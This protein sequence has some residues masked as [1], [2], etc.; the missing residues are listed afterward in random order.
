MKTF[1]YPLCSIIL[2]TVVITFSS[3]S[4]DEEKKVAEVSFDGTSQ[5]VNEA[6]GFIFIPFD[7]DDGPIADDAELSFEVSGTATLDEDYIYDGWDE[8][9]VYF[10][11]VDDD[12]FEL[13]ETLILEITDSEKV[14]ISSPDTHTVTIVDNDTDTDL[15]IDLTWNAGGG[16]PGDVDMDLILWE[17]D[18]V[19][20]IFSDI[21]A[22]AQFGTAFES[23][24][25]PGSAADGT[26]G[27]T[28]QYWEG[29]SNNLQFTVTFTTEN[30]TLEG[31]E[32]ELVFSETYTLNN[33]NS[34]SNVLIEQLFD[35]VGADYN[36]FSIIDVP[37]SGSR[38]K[39][40]EIPLK[41]TQAPNQ[42]TIISGKK[43]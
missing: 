22:S 28:Y 4:D 27:L 13:D 11:L 9:G 17:Y 2:L 25:L 23:V 36:N 41:G 8:D 37:V 18:P 29:T 35:K 16:T 10:I 24:T 33:V 32:K 20:E 14:N 38:I 15:V 1:T 40:Y 43:R 19:N 5:I 31:T 6:E 34:S 21:A 26:Y 12:D 42:K 39:S 30:G 7:V 3:C